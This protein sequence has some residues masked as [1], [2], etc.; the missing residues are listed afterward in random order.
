MVR[1]HIHIYRY[2]YVRVCSPCFSRATYRAKRLRSPPI[3]SLL[4]HDDGG[5][6][7]IYRTRGTKRD[8]EP[9]CRKSDQRRSK[10]IES[11]I[12]TGF[13]KGDKEN[14]KKI[15]NRK[16]SFRYNGCLESIV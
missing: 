2:Y 8:D 15:S 14:L 7:M 1:Y 6:S 9:G 10:S 13:P 11:T 5:S 12:S 3:R 16:T 4:S